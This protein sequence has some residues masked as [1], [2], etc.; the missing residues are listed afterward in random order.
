MF[1]SSSVVSLLLSPAPVVSPSAIL[2]LRETPK[3]LRGRENVSRINIHKVD[4]VDAASVS[5]RHSCSLF[6]IRLPL[7]GQN[8]ITRQSIY[9]ESCRQQLSP[10]GLKSADVVPV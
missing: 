4:V 1:C 10:S 2:C 7:Q 9:T 8:G 6:L 3:G 5:L